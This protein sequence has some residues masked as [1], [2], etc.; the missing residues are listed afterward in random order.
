MWWQYQIAGKTN[1]LT[2]ESHTVGNTCR[3]PGNP[4]RRDVH[5]GVEGSKAY[6]YRLPATAAKRGLSL[7]VVLPWPPLERHEKELSHLNVRSTPVDKHLFA[8]QDQGECHPLQEALQQ[9]H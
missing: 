8:L 2:Q 1:H 5:N 3:D 6:R 9:P 4:G 7:G